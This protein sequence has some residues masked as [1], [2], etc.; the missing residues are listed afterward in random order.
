VEP[1]Q[2]DYKQ[3][4]TVESNHD[5]LGV[6]CRERCFFLRKLVPFLSTLLQGVRL[7]LQLVSELPN[8]CLLSVH[9][10]AKLNQDEGLRR[11]SVS[12]QLLSHNE[13]GL[14]FY[15]LFCFGS[16]FRCKAV[17]RCEN[18]PGV[19]HVLRASTL[20]EI[21]QTCKV[22]FAARLF[23]VLVNPLLPA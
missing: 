3:R 5:F 2:L 23:R 16:F 6:V 21:L 22:T 13:I 17:D 1:I 10:F 19:L 9:V 7:C 20:D 12:R 14:Q 15:H 4:E 8:L 11:S 18:G